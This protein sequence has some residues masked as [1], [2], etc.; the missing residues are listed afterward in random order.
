[1]S[2]K[3]K[4]NRPQPILNTIL[5]L[6][7]MCCLLPLVLVVIVSFTDQ[8]SI[9]EIGFSF[10]PKAFSLEG[11]NYVLDYSDQLIQS[12]KITLYEVI[13][14]TAITLLLTSMFAYALSRKDWVLRGF[15]S[16]FLLISMLFH[17]GLVSNYLIF[18]SVYHL[19]DNLLILVLP[20]AVTAFNCFTM[21]TFIQSNIPD[22]LIEA[23]RIDG[24]KEMFLFF[25]VVMPLMKPS[26]A[27]I[28]FMSAVG[29]W[30]EWQTSM[31]YISDPNK[32]TLQLLLVRIEKS[33]EY[34]M[35][36]LAY[37]TPEEMRRF[38]QAPGE[39]MRMAIL[40]VTMGP[41]LIAYPFFQKYFVK[42]ITVGAVKG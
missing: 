8:S 3:S 23:A 24:A 32:A 15:F 30:N 31:L 25:R 11:W 18:T 20:G 37:L 26:L 36:N 19:K 27:A 7:T 4:L 42:G 14:G 21:R 1:M 12:Y 39:S 22:S 29:H 13:V 17:G 16:T 5:L 28:G 10:F 35:E 6:L 41:I 2:K 33:I 34:L 38:E 9:E 40:V